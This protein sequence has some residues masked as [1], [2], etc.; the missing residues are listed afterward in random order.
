MVQSSV[1][2]L[3]L[4]GAPELSSLTVCGAKELPQLPNYL[5]TAMWGWVTG[6]RYRDRA[7]QNLNINLLR[8]ISLAATCYQAG[9]H[10]LL[11]YVDGLAAQQHRLA[12]Y[13]SALHHFEQCLAANWEAAELDD[14]CQRRLLGMPKGKLTIFEEHDGSVFARINRL[15]NLVKHFSAEDAEVTSAPVWI[16]NT[17]LKCNGPAVTFDELYGLVLELSN[18]ARLIF[19]DLPQRA[20]AKARATGRPG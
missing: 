11:G 10:S 15:N 16:T 2:L 13:L 3:D 1:Q 5:D 20:Q 6:T 18:L 17:G 14:R 12:D 19:V 9:R 8:R 7:V 4:F